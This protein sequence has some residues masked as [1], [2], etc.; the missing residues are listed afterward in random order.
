M[1]EH[2]GWVRGNW[3]VRFEAAHMRTCSNLLA[4]SEPF[5]KPFFASTARSRWATYVEFAAIMRVE[6]VKEV[7]GYWSD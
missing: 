3:P 7:N 4:H 2:F 1:G 6:R 5:G